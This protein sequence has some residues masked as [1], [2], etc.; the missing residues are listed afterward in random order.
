MS[1]RSER[2]RRATAYHEAGHA[3]MAVVHRLPLRGVDIVETDARLL[4]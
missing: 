4:R 2:E 1:K 3:V